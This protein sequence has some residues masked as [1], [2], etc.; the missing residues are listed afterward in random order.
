MRS[1]GA[2]PSD[3]ELQDILQELDQQGTPHFCYMTSQVAVIIALICS[4]KLSCKLSADD[5][6][7]SYVSTGDGTISFI[8]F[9]SMMAEKMKETD[10]AQQIREALRGE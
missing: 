2:S 4:S 9:I 5:V 7:Q 1:A 10:S 6:I 8:A 3:A